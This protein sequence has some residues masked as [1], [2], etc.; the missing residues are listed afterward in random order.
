MFVPLINLE[1]IKE[2]KNLKTSEFYS[3]SQ[4]FNLILNL[5]GR[6]FYISKRLLALKP[7]LNEW[8]KC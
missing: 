2:K 7:K 6:T 3:L 1:V 4:G 5:E 8:T